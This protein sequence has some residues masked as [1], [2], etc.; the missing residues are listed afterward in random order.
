MLKKL[1]I[2]H[3]AIIDDLELD[4]YSGMT[5]LT[6]ETGAGKSIIIDA[7]SLLL[8]ERADKTM[9][10]S[11]AEEAIVEGVFT[12][13][14]HALKN[15]LDHYEIEYH[16]EIMLSRTISKDNQNAIK[17][18]NQRVTLKII[19]EMS[20][21][22]A[23]I[24]SQFDTSQLIH[25]E[26]YLKLIDNFR[27]DKV[28]EYL[29]AY[30][31][32]LDQYLSAYKAYENLKNKRQ[33]S[34]Q[35][36]DLYQFQLK[37]LSNLELSEGELEELNEKV[38]VL[39]NIDKINYNLA[40]SYSMINDQ[41]I[42]ENLYHIKN[43]IDE[44]SGTT[45]DLKDISERMN[46]LYYELKDLND[47]IEYN[48][49]ALEY[50]PSELE[51]MNQRINELEKIQKKYQ[52]SIS[53]LIIYQ[54]EL[55]DMIDEIENYDELIIKKEMQVETKHKS[56]VNQAV[57]L[58]NLRKT[59]AK[60]ITIEII[61]TLKELEIKHAD[62]RIDFE[63]F[64][65]DNVFDR[66]VFKQDGVDRVDFMISTNKGE[67]LKPLSKTASGGEMSRVMLT[68]KTIFAKSQKIPT[69]IFDE[70]DTG[71]SGYVAKQ[72]GRKISQTAKFAQVISITHIP[73]VV[74]EGIHHL[75]IKKDIIDDKT[76]IS[77]AY[78]NYD[79]RVE[80]IAKMMSADAVTNAAR[81]IAKELLIRT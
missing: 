41:G 56:L 24:H 48:Q 29:S 54:E 25:P 32:H 3:F 6:G 14:G 44:I 68:F 66:D 20:A 70:I 28:L 23:D 80:E 26:Q 62:F 9:I 81:D 12:I 38:N 58:S 79:E 43:N 30:Q 1:K 78:L 61:D 40:E 16:D 15:L 64:K 46:N 65:F 60:K 76:K 69:I 4:F 39:N 18:N 11:N 19:N 45:K 17:V 21:F 47:E 13:E 77:V 50:D 73:Q 34:L 57:Q 72:I 8:G 37:E 22:L 52:K 53:E 63:D 71:I 51:T 35:E 31:N 49:E 42:L 2:K 75:C 7:I 10:R 33:K 67:P 59:I 27:K 36:L 74:A 5:V 55:T